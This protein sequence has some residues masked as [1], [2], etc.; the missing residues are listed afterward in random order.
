M[1]LLSNVALFLASGLI[2]SSAQAAP[3]ELLVNGNF[4]TGNLTGWTASKTA[5]SS[6]CCDGRFTVGTGVS[7]TGTGSLTKIGGSYSAFGDF[8][9]GIDGAA[10]SATDI[11]LSQTFTKTSDFSA[12]D[13]SFQFQVANGQYG[14]T[15]NPSIL[16]RTLSIIFSSGGSSATA[17]TY[18]VPDGALGVHPLQTVSLNVAELLNALPDGAVTMTID[19]RSPQYYTGQGYFVGDNFSLRAT[20]AAAVPEPGTTALLGLGILGFAVARRRKVSAK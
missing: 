2:F 18:I 7:T 1:K 15:N 14:S 5:G 4:E 10:S 8:D 19:R 12:A 3:I 13:L 6:L 9:G 17:Y 11:F 20:A 16:A